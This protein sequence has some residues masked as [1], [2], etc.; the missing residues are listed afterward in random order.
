M[1][2]GKNRVNDLHRCLFSFHSGH[3]H[4]DAAAFSASISASN[5]SF[6]ALIARSSLSN[7]C[8]SLSL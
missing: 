5:N 1:K 4:S 3:P 7:N 8:L 6:L 2:R